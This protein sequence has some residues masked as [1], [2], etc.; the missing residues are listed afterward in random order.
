MNE[1]DKRQSQLLMPMLNGFE[2]GSVS[3]RS[4]ISNLEVLL[5]NMQSCELSWKAAMEHEWETLEEVYSVARIRH[6][7]GSN[8]SLETLTKP[9]AD[10][11]D[12]PC[13]EEPNSPDSLTREMVR[14]NQRWKSP[15][16]Y[17]PSPKKDDD[18]APVSNPFNNPL[19]WIPKLPI[20][21]VP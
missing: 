10:Q 16:E 7:E 19:W 20:P 1:F 17:L 5:A 18:D 15:L 8:N 2:Q 4:L 3:L 9:G 11:K 21:V 14:H 6:E 12:R 13:D